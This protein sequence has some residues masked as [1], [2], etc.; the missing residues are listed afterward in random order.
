MKYTRL[1]IGLFV[2]MTVSFTVLGF[3][4]RQ[5]YRMAPPIPQ[6][7]V[8]ADGHVLCTG[9]DIRDGQNVWQSTGGQEMGTVW[10]HGSY[11]APDWSADWL[12]REATFMLDAMAQ[13]EFD[14]KDSASLDPERQAALKEAL[15]EEVRENTYDPMTGDL[16]VSPLRA[17]A[18]A[19]VGKHY[20]GLYGDDPALAGLREAYA[21]PENAVPSADRR[22]LLNAFFFWTA[23][24]C[25][26]NRPGESVTYTQNWPPESL[27]GNAPT[28]PIILWS[29]A[30]F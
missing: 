21:M 29:V 11:V 8:A 27:I 25:S 28:G 1:W 30:S 23:W 20:A 2:V 4:G 6:R 24:A 17:Q 12:H 16:T 3:F 9:Q 5:L 19:E 18:F 10:G 26:T 15:K 14:A 22:R 13:S 7:V